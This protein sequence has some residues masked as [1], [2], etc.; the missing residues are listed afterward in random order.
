MPDHRSKRLA[1]IQMIEARK[2]R[3]GKTPS[4]S[5]IKPHIRAILDRTRAANERGPSVGS[6]TSRTR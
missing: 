2:K 4:P 5:T 6:R 3:Q 1:P